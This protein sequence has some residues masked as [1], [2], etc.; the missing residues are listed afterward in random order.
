MATELTIKIKT[1]KHLGK[2]PQVLVT[3]KESE[4]TKEERKLCGLLIDAMRTTFV[5]IH[6]KATTEIV[7]EIGGKT[8]R[9]MEEEFNK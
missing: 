2:G 6:N 8:A 7:A 1:R 9:R 4:C 3:P 5:E